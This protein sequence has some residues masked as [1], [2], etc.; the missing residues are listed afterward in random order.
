MARLGHISH[1]VVL[2]G[3]SISN[4]APPTMCH[5]KKENMPQS[6]L[7][8]LLIISHALPSQML[9][10]AWLRINEMCFITP[11]LQVRMPRHR[12]GKLLT[13]GHTARRQTSH[14]LSLGSW[15]R[16]PASNHSP[17]FKALLVHGL[18]TNVFHILGEHRHLFTAFLWLHCSEM[19][20]CSQSLF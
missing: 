1:P 18:Y 12:K 6:R 11:I 19:L 15:S 17:I 10:N 14:V 2:R 20:Q 7:E 16:A 5:L 9:K 13:R 4:D 3:R 8:L